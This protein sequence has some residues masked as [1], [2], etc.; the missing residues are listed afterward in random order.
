MDKKT[1]LGFLGIFSASFYM[2]FYCII[3]IFLA[4]MYSTFSNVSPSFVTMIMT[5]PQL[6][7][8]IGSFIV[9][10]LISKIDKKQEKMYI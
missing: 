1:K 6:A 8:V 4:S 7:S 3:Q 2:Y 10:P 5:I 9:A